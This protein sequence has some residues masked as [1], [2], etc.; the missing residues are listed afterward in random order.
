MCLSC[1]LVSWHEELSIDSH[2]QYLEILHYFINSDEMMTVCVC[3]VA[4]S[5]DTRNCR[6]TFIYSSF[7]LWNNSFPGN[8][9]VRVYVCRVVSSVG[10]NDCR[11]TLIYSS[12]RYYNISL[13]VM[14]WWRFV[15]VVSSRQL[16]R[17][18]VD[19]HS[20]TVVWDANIFR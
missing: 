11:S 12:W 1:R 17:R 3:R 2:L 9:M 4:S 7:R 10:T 19:R 15:F 18:T 8:K 13:T 14:K 16:A 20:F 5:I 6:S